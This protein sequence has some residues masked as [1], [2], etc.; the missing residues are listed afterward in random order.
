MNP[1]LK[2]C[3]GSAAITVGLPCILAITVYVLALSLNPGFVDVAD[4]FFADVQAGH[5]EK[6]YVRT[7]P[8]TRRDLS[9]QVFGDFLRQTGLIS[10]ES[11]RWE[12]Y[13]T[14]NDTTAELRGIAL[15]RGSDPQSP[16]N[17]RPIR[18]VFTGT[19]RHW[20]I[21]SIE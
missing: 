6:A 2:T 4:R 13:R 8:E 10:F 15:L 14:V 12:E 7:A 5:L 17:S 11:A 20:K 21:L 3:L 9:L 19:R 18:L 1:R 16:L